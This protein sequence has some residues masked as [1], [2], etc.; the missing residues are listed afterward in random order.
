MHLNQEMVRSLIRIRKGNFQLVEFEGCIKIIQY[1]HT[2][3]DLVETLA[4]IDSISS[5]KRK[6]R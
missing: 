4:I 2:R 5:E 6:E 3:L 1:E